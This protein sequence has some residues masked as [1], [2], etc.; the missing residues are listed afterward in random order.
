MKVLIARPQPEAAALAVLLKDQGHDC[1][2]WPALHF[3]AARDQQSQRDFVAQ[4]TRD[5]SVIVTSQQVLR[6]ADSIVLAILKK[7]HCFAIGKSTAQALQAMRVDKV[8]YPEIPG[9]EGLLALL[10]LQQSVGRVVWLLR[11][12]AGREWLVTALC[13][14]GK[15]VRP[16]CCYQREFNTAAPE[17]LLAYLKQPVDLV[18]ATSVSVLQSLKHAT[19]QH[20][21]TLWQTVPVTVIGETML[22][23]ANELGCQP[24]VV[25]Q[26]DNDYMAQWVEQYY[27]EHKQ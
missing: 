26:V 7:R 2:V 25:P 15:R 10:V 20:D 1:L 5:D 16:V 11:A 19:A 22:N 3:T 6:Y 17:E 24:M 14:Q 13:Q 12:Q 23:Y 27:H 4:S 9:G 18:I 21:S 8:D